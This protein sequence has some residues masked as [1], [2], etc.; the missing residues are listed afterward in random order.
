M[1]IMTNPVVL[2][3]IPEKMASAADVDLQVNV[4]SGSGADTKETDRLSHERTTDYVDAY[5][6]AHIIDTNGSDAT[7]SYTDSAGVETE[8]SNPKNCECAT[9]NTSD[10]TCDDHDHTS[11]DRSLLSGSTIANVSIVV[12]LAATFAQREHPVSE[13]TMKS[14]NITKTTKS[15][16][17]LV[18]ETEGP[19]SIT[20]DS[21]S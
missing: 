21:C 20:H 3:V 7:F 17:N 12:D 10:Q 6:V 4:L 8:T 5:D 18:P 16:S 11:T 14:S 9:K 1:I 2:S 13:G 15:K 19:S